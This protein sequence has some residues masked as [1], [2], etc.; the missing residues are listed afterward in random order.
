GAAAEGDGADGSRLWRFDLSQ[1]TRAQNYK[2][3]VA[4]V[5]SPAYDIALA[6]EPQAV[7]FEVEYVPP[8]YA[9]LPVQRG[10]ATRGDV[11]ALR[12]TEARVEA[13]F[14]RDLDRVEARLADGA[15]ARWT[16]VTPRRWRG[17]IPIAQDGEY[18]LTATAPGGEARFRYRVTPLPDAPPVTG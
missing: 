15:H 9:R 11:S 10:T 13:L 6:G 1:L 14:D 8:A 12:G 16:A 17:V 4:G 3:R 2:V 7:S 5:E 18:E